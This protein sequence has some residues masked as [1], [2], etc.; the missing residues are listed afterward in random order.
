[1]EQNRPNELLPCPCGKIPKSI[2]I[3][4]GST[5][6]YA[7]VSGTCCGEWAIEFRTNNKPI[8]N[9]ETINLGKIAWNNA[10]RAS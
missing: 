10:S 3:E 6:T 4:A 5:G 1:M 7:W 8:W 2:V 9:V